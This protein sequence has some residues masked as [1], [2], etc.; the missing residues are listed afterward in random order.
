[1]KTLIRILQ[2]SLLGFSMAMPALAQELPPIQNFR[3]SDY[4]AGNQN[5][6]LSQSEDKVIYLAN[7]EGLLI[8]NGAQWLS[9]RLPNETIVRSVNVIGDKIYTGS[10]MEFGYWT[11]KAE[12]RLGYHSLSQEL[13]LEMVED[14]EIWKIMRVDDWIVFQSLKRIYIYQP[15]TK[16]L[17]IIESN[18]RITNIFPTKEKLLFQRLG[19]GIFEIVDG[20]DVRFLSNDVL[21]EDEVIAIL[22]SKEEGYTL[23]TKRHGLY[24]YAG[25]DLQS[26]ESPVDTYLNLELYSAIRLS[27]GHLA[28]GTISEGIFVL[29]EKQ[30]LKIKIDQKTGLLNNTVLSLF[31]DQDRNLWAGLDNGASMIEFEAPVRVFKDRE[32]MFGSVYATAIFG[33]FLYLGTNQGLYKRPLSKPAQ[34]FEP[35]KSMQGQVWHLT[36]FDDMLWVSHHNGTYTL[37]GEDVNRIGKTLGTWRVHP[38][39]ANQCIQGNYDGLYVL[40]K[41]AGRWYVKNK[42]EGFENSSRYFEKV[43]STLLVN[44]EYRGVF[45]LSLS[46]DLARVKS[47]KIDTMLRGANSGLSSF[48]D[49]I[50]YCSKEGFYGFDTRLGRFVKDTLLSQYMRPETYVS[51]RMLSPK[52]DE[53][54]VFK[55]D[56][57]IKISSDRM[58]NQLKVDKVPL[59][60]SKRSNVVEYENIIA[61]PQTTAYLIGTSYGYLI[62]D[63]EKWEINPFIVSINAIKKHPASGEKKRDRYIPLHEKGLFEAG[64]NHLTLSFHSTSRKNF[65]PTAYQYQ[66]AGLYERWSD[67]SAASHISFENVPPGDY[68]FRVRS[69]VGNTLSENIAT[70]RF[71]I[72]K[73]WYAKDAAIAIYI[74]CVVIFSIFMHN[75][76]RIYYRKQQ[77]K[78]IEKNKQEIELEKLRSEKE[79][80]KIQN[81]QLE[82]ENKNKNNELAASTMSVIKKNEILSAIKEQL[83]S[84]DKEKI[85]QPV[86]K[87]INKNLSHKE[88]W[89]MFKGAFEMTDGAFF[90]NLK[91][92]HPNLSPNDLKLCAYLKLNLSS[93]EVSQLINISPRSVE[94][95]RYRL[96][97]KLGLDNNENLTDY[98]LNI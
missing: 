16:Q 93:K 10:F 7:N 78:L 20:K 6:S 56:E 37:S 2:V 55:S 8:H 32:G 70:Y 62:L 28:L 52:N 69:K 51:G 98:I 47:V 64:D 49:N 94:V 67:W 34:P 79:L 84:L 97:K 54:W 81:Q 45:M 95:K 74:L 24:H 77:A 72:L 1:M 80:V 91:Q 3:P 60:A 35:I 83:E 85:T 11:K 38:I 30:N 5:W 27:N 66:L 53:L 63:Y 18:T 19:E 9:Y 46:E 58:S 88:N 22:D 68:A 40:E 14:E 73:P 39:S 17:R 29:D 71:Q 15:I 75:V 96:R 23:I 48:K 89:E 50:Y 4:G 61:I 33:E 57:L 41:K 87:M 13:N 31:E 12:G 59:L 25:D 21:K 26:L 92:K 44:H 90:K 86:I 65:L 36:V 82:K 42:I 43:E 76:Y